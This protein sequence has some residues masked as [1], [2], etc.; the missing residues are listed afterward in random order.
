MRFA[1]MWWAQVTIHSYTL[2]VAGGLHDLL[3]EV[4]LEDVLQLDD[5]CYK[6]SDSL[7]ELLGCHGV[8][9]ESESES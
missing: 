6:E 9:I 1:A 8:F 2:A 5:V 4:L 3:G 7:R